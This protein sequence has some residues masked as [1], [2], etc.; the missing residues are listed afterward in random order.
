MSPPT[1][2]MKAENLELAKCLS[3]KNRDD[4]DNTDTNTIVLK[5]SCYDFKKS[6]FDRAFI[7]KYQIVVSLSSVSDWFFILKNLAKTSVPK[8]GFSKSKFAQVIFIVRIIPTQPRA[9]SLRDAT[10]PTGHPFSSKTP[11][12]NSQ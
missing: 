9:T 4:T 2:E 7:L 5:Y 12:Q 10:V 3:L 1:P 6:D 8:I 11:K